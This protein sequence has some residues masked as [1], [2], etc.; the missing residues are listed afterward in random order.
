MDAVI[1]M[2]THYLYRHIRLDKNEPFYV[3]IGNYK[4]DICKKSKKYFRAYSRYGR[5]KF[6]KDITNKTDYKVQIILESSNYQ[7]ILDKEKE[8]V[9]IYGRRNLN[10]GTLCNLRPG[11]EW[12]PT[13]LSVKGYNQKAI[14]QYDLE[15]NFIKEWESG[16]KI[17]QELKIYSS[18]IKLVVKGKGSHSHNYQWRYKTENYPLK[19]EKVT[20][21][22]REVSQ[23]NLNGEFIKKYDTIKEAALNNNISTSD[24]ILCCQKQR[25]TAKNFQWRYYDESL[26]NIGKFIKNKTK[27]YTK[28]IQQLSLEGDLI[29]EGTISQLTAEGF[30]N[31]CIYSVCNGKSIQHKGFKF[32]YKE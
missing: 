19:I 26:K 28:V 17:E 32:K 25:G 21:R 4:D 9:E 7:F 2:K 8:F 13:G 27:P 29:K 30:L 5:T 24:I 3:G 15:G 22:K 11:G 31:C 16:Y 12:C 6:W 14:L 20:I 10:T 18:Y 1:K 23:Y